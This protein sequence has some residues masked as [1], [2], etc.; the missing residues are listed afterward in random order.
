MGKE[1]GFWGGGDSL[2]LEKPVDEADMAK[3][4]FM[5]TW[6]EWETGSQSAMT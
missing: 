4:S 1:V 2:P 3:S 6:S 5:V